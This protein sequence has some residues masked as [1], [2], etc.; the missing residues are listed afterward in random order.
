MCFLTRTFEVWLKC[1]WTLCPTDGSNKPL[2]TWYFLEVHYFQFI[3]SVTNDKIAFSNRVQRVYLD[4]LLVLKIHEFHPWS[5]GLCT[6]DEKPS[7]FILCFGTRWCVFLFWF[8]GK[9][10]SLRKEG[11]LVA[12]V[13][14]GVL[15]SL[16]V[17]LDLPFL[18]CEYFALYIL[19][20]FC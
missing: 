18:L 8:K 3:V 19:S 2:I 11:G 10:E 6:R 16:A 12:K 5:V 9:T 7:E 15:R 17:I 1:K 14:K 4:W 13:E 20:F